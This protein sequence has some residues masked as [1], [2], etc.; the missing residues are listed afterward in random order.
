MTNIIELSLSENFL[1]L[2]PTIAF[3]HLIRLQTLDLSWNRI[4]EISN[5]SFNKLVSLRKLSLERNN[6]SYIDINSFA[7]LINL[8][9]INLAS[10]H[11][12]ILNPDSFILLKNLHTLYLESNEWNCNCRMQPF[13]RMLI[14]QRYRLQIIDQPRCSGTSVIWSN[15]ALDHFQC[16]PKIYHNV[17]D[18]DIT[19]SEGS[20]LRMKCAIEIETFGDPIVDREYLSLSNINWYWNNIQIM[21]NSKGCDHNCNKHMPISHS[22]E[23]QID[24]SIEELNATIK[25]KVS[26]LALYSVMTLNAGNYRCSVVNHA[27][28][29]EMFYTVYVVPYYSHSTNFFQNDQHPKVITP[30]NTAKRPSSDSQISYNK[31]I[32]NHQDESMWFFIYH[33]H[34]FEMI[35]IHSFFIFIFTIFIM[36][37]MPIMFYLV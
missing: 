8:Q 6:I 18:T 17:S 1:T 29:D 33:H 21:N 36:Q 27:G 32:I 31:N 24:E 20:T 12:T 26:Q 10:N 15:L 13:K 30:A 11:L 5:N 3:E 9:T 16:A 25:I 35:I 37:Q 22:Q 19:L 14:Q 34:V 23:F 28:S 4:R 2:I 7:G